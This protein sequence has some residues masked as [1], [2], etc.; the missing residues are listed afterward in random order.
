MVLSGSGLSWDC[1]KVSVTSEIH[2]LRVCVCLCVFPAC[3]L[4]KIVMKRR[5]RQQCPLTVE[6]SSVLSQL[7][8]K[9][10]VVLGVVPKWL[11]RDTYV[12]TGS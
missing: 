5:N 4:N 9:E 6:Q 1:V 8:I 11:T 2:S 12:A 7:K 10:R 3:P